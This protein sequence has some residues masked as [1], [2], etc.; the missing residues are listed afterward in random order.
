MKQYTNIA[1]SLAEVFYE[2][3]ILK[4]DSN[5][6][7]L[8]KCGSAVGQTDFEQKFLADEREA[9]ERTLSE[10]TKIE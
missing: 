5:Y 9:Y 4:T 6:S 3:C 8:P 1:R 2:I 7:L 10:E